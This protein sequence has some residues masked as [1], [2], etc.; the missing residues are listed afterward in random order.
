MSRLMLLTLAHAGRPGEYMLY[1]KLILVPCFSFGL[2]L[3]DKLILEYM[4][5]V[6]EILLRLSAMLTLLSRDARRMEHNH[7]VKA[8]PV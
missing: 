5:E 6:A 1:A 7:I 4:F 3:S 8:D 2:V